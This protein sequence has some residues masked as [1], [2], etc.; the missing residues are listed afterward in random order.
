M[1][2]DSALPPTAVAVIP[3]RRDDGT[4]TVTVFF[5]LTEALRE[6]LARAQRVL[7]SPTMERVEINLQS[8]PDVHVF[9]DG[10]VSGVD[11]ISLPAV[12]TDAS[13]STLDT[14][15]TS[16]GVKVLVTQP[17]PDAFESLDILPVRA[18]SPVELQC[19]RDGAVVAHKDMHIAGT[20]ETARS[21]HWSWAQLF[22]DVP[23]PL[24]F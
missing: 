9:R 12:L 3:L 13:A 24:D 15:L 20:G 19:T 17:V 23:L 7:A 6:H 4:W 5:E 18:W 21:A 22:A 14:G 8:V 16:G 2:T 1:S 10:A 11:L